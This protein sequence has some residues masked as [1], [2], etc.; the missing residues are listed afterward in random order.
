MAEKDSTEWAWTHWAGSIAQL[1]EAARLAMEK[2][3]ALAP[4]PDDYD[5]KAPGYDS[6]K[7]K[8]WLRAEDAHRLSISTA[9]K[10]GYSSELADLAELDEIPERN[11]DEIESIAITVGNGPYSPPSVIMRASRHGGL[12]LTV[13]GY[14][15]TWTAGLRHELE[16]VLRPTRRLY[17]PLVGQ[18]PGSIIA[19]VLAF[20]VVLYGLVISLNAAT[21]WEL[22][23]R[24]VVALGCALV[25]A[26]AIQAVRVASSRQL[27]LLRPGQEPR[28]Q[29]WRGKLFAGVWAVILSVIASLIYAV[30]SS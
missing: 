28:Y 14:E 11:F 5:P 30:L 19:V 25:A 23:T 9:E 4:Y 16:Q 27:E 12:S 22:A 3:R 13:N 20:N 18:D 7:H 6:A 10:D 17:A 24:G 29:R 8:A 21:D 15:R 2:V 26:L 1:T